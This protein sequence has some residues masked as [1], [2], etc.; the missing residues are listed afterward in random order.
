MSLP[1]HPPQVA[2]SVVSTN[3]GLL[4]PCFEGGGASFLLDKYTDVNLGS[5]DVAV[6]RKQVCVD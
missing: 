5:P 6:Q 3:A 1:H 2:I 4:A